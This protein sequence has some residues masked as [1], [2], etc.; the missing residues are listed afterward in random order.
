MPPTPKVISVIPATAATR[1]LLSGCLRLSGSS[2]KRHITTRPPAHSEPEAGLLCG[3]ISIVFRTELEEAFGV[4]AHR[5]YFR[6]RFADMNVAAF[7][8]HPHPVTVT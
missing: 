5:T 6:S 7:A 1:E 2:D 3:K 4:F 8:T